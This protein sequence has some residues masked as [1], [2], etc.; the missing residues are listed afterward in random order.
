M[1][2]DILEEDGASS[3]IPRDSS[4]QT[5]DTRS[6]FFHALPAFDHSKFSRSTLRKQS[7][8]CM[9]RCTFFEVTE[10]KEQ[11]HVHREDLSIPI[12]GTR[13]GEIKTESDRN[14]NEDEEKRRDQ[15]NK[16]RGRQKSQAQRSRSDWRLTPPPFRQHPNHPLT[17]ARWEG[18]R[19]TRRVTE[20]TEREDS[21]HER[22]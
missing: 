12:D 15:K 14:D 16:S 8:P 9:S 4:H 21:R 5:G 6:T 10:K 3:N 19:E 13:E 22:R 2:A 1:T 17:R 20:R 18:V 11:D 7:P